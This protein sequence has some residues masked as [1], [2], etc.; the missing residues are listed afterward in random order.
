MTSPYDLILYGID[1]VLLNSFKL[2]NCETLS[3]HE[4][5]QS[6]LMFHWWEQTLKW[7]SRISHVTNDV[8]CK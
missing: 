6:N 1:E 5:C 3:I 8:E 2:Q 4:M 7:Q